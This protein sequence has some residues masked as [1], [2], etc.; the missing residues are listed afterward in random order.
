MPRCAGSATSTRPAWAASPAATRARRPTTDCERAARRPR[1]STRSL[2]ATPVCTHVELASASLEAG[3]HTFVEKPL[4]A[5]AIEADELLELAARARARADVRAHVHLQPA[6]AGGEEDARRRRA[7][8][9][10]LRLLEPGQPR[11]A[12]ARRQRDLGPRARTTS[13]SC[14]T[15]STSCPE[16]VAACGR[17]AVV[18][19]IADVAFVSLGF[20]SGTLA[21]LEMSWLAPSKL[22]RTVLVGSEKMVVYE[23]GAPEPVRLFDRRRRLPR[24]RDVRRV[25]PLLPHRRH[26]L[27]PARRQRAAGASRSTTSS[28]PCAT[29]SPREGHVELALDVVRMIEAAETSLVE[30]GGA[31]RA[32]SRRSRD[33]S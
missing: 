16:T 18:E 10:V 13:R 27:A 22:R 8:R 26:R 21:N 6:G 20:G 9:S 4:A 24:P 5:S 28:T 14:A 19:G 3:K 23:D 12:S 15:G 33:G 17:D 29:G 2:I 25:P 11:P 32:S 31:G 30:G 7:R 1:S